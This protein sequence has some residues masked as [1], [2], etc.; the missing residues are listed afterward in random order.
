M[1]SALAG[2]ERREFWVATWGQFLVFAGFS[3]FFQ[4]PVFIKVLGGTESRIGIIMGFTPIAS[5]FLLPWVASVVDRA[6][7]KVLMMGGG[8]VL[9][10]GSIAALALDTPGVGM[11]VLMTIRGLGFVL[12]L[13]ANGAHLARILP[14]RER[15][16]WFGIYYAFWSIAAAVGPGLGEAVIHYWGFQAFFGVSFA[17]V[18]TGT[19]LPLGLRGE[20]AGLEALWTNPFPGIVS[21]FR[22]LLQPRFRW[23]FFSMLLM[24]G[25]FASVIGFTA[26]YLQL[27][28][29]SS[30]VFFATYAVT[31]VVSRL[32]GGGLS[33]RLGRTVV[34]VPAMLVGCGSMMVYS[35][36]QG[37]ITMMIAAGL[38][39]LGF[40]FANPA[41]SAHMVDRAPPKLQGIAVGGFQF[42]FNLG[43]VLTTPLMG[44][45]ADNMGYRPMWWSGS[46]LVFGAA[47]VYLIKS[48]ES[49]W[50]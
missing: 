4:F 37:L 17:I 26:T 16:R 40:G 42:A 13:V 50:A 48:R 24:A 1:P 15:A 49:T 14:P 5:T 19:L 23:L 29:L 22:E 28:G 32:W 10:L 38:A 20:S 11:A 30:G 47:L 2:P 3:M 18:V 36:T 45:I 34:V 12:Y 35:F 39:G 43:M 7:R 21:F 25:G 6:N 44:A 9:A 8:G 41:I 46:A 33:D 27:L 31:S